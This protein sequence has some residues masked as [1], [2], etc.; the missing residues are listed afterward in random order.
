MLVVKA[1]SW[2]NHIQIL[3]Q[4]SVSVPVSGEVATSRFLRRI[5]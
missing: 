4:G 5:C 3:A 2:Y 1:V